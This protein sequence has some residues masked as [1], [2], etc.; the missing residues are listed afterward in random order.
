[1]KNY[2]VI[3]LSFF[4]IF[5]CT[6]KEEIPTAESIYISAFKLLKNKNYLD[7]AKEFEKIDDEFP[8]SKW[9]IK[10]QVM[11]SYAYFKN[12]DF[13]KVIQISEDFTRLNPVNK[14]IPYMLYMK[15]LCYYLQIP[16]ITRAQ[17]NSKQAS[18]IFREL[19]AKFPE[20]DHAIDAIEKLKFIDEHL[21][22]AHLSQARHQI[23]IENYIGAI[24]NLQF[25]INRYRNSSQLPEAFF[26]LAEI[27]CFLGEVKECQKAKAI[28]ELNFFESQW[29][30]DSQKIPITN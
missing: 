15:G 6:K 27:Y 8:F 10:G 29:Y 11:A 25:M 13:D 16:S 12:K 17:D 2:F 22:G 14:Y 9:A 18:M 21:A 4:L 20:S 26:R 7:S 3:L 5:S 23:K 24:N 30:I 28:L 19:I 1:M